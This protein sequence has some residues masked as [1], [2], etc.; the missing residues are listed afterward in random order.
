MRTALLERTSPATQTDAFGQLVAGLVPHSFPSID[1]VGSV[2]ERLRLRHGMH[3]G[4][5]ETGQVAYLGVSPGT[6]SLRVRTIPGMDLVSA[7]GALDASDPLAVMVA[8]EVTRRGVLDRRRRCRVCCGVMDDAIAQDT[9]PDC[10]DGYDGTPKRRAITMWSRGSRRRMTRAIAEL[11]LS[12]WHEDGGNLCLVTFT[13]PGW[14]EVVAPTGRDFK[15]LVELLR[16][17]WLRAGAGPWRGMW[18][19]EFQGRGAPH[20]HALMR[21]PATVGGQVFE[22][23]LAR[24]WADVCL[25]SLSDRDALAYI[26]LGEYDKHLAK[27]TD[28][29]WSGVRFS[30][31]RRTS[32]YFLKHAAP[33]DGM[34]SKE[35]QH[36]VPALWQS[37]GDGPGRFW[38]IWGLR[39]ATGEMSVDWRT[40]CQARRVL[41]H[42]A[43][44]SQARTEMSRLRGAGDPAG[45]W[46][47]RRQQRRAGFGA[48]GGGWVLVND[49]VSLALDLGRA[50]T[51]MQ[52]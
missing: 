28:L 52:D 15:R 20:L 30:D 17:R 21:V 10:D 46:S 23:W 4:A 24:T 5:N 33:G 51:V 31:P 2:V 47:M 7:D 16:R 43:R 39:R 48:T 50:L 1:D 40:F 34:G 14:W 22:T 26:G 13:L 37:E 19:L 6:V 9:H 27:G 38:G 8:G 18:K 44:A 11:D 12:T 3:V 29:S 32:I 45:V 25:D 49:G 42:V 35:Y 41:R 36:V